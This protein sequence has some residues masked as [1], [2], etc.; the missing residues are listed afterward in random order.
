MSQRELGAPYTHELIGEAREDGCLEGTRRWMSGRQ[1]VRGWVEAV[2]EDD[3]QK[4]AVL[5]AMMAALAEEEDSYENYEPG[6][7]A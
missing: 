2:I 6:G 1:R 7:S 4:L 3:L 5:K